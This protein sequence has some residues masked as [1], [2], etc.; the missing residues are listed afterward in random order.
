MS[1]ALVSVC[2]VGIR[3]PAFQTRDPGSIPGVVRD[4]TTRIRFPALTGI[5]ISILRRAVLS[6]VV[7]GGD[8]DNILI[9]DSERPDL[10]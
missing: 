2:G 10:M 6:C 1:F 5:L 4:F 8:L 3:V 9:T 7:S